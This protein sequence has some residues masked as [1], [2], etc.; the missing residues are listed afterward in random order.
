MDID[1][2]KHYNDTFGHTKGDQVLA[3]IG[4]IISE[5]IRKSDS[6]FRYGGEEFVIIM[7]ETPLE[8]AAKIAERIR[9]KFASTTFCPA[10]DERI[11]KTVS[12]GLTQYT[13]PENQKDLLARADQNMYQA[14]KS[15]KNRVIFS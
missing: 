9:R 2:F 13:P 5:G 15:G 11:Q 8:A 14:K 6:G 4:K 12:I 1:D 3:G 7:P 10:G